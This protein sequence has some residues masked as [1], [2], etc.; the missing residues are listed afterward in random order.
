M[1]CS[2]CL[3]VVSKVCY[4]YCL[5][6]YSW[7]CL[8]TINDLIPEFTKLFLVIHIFLII[9]VIINTFL[10]IFCKKVF[11]SKFL[12][13]NSYDLRFEIW[14]FRWGMTNFVWVWSRGGFY[15]PYLTNT[16]NLDQ[17]APHYR[18]TGFFH[19]NTSLQ[20]IETVKTRFRGIVYQ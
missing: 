20:P 10:G 8:G 1:S 17:P 6:G 7:F 4:F 19:T 12:T 15:Q 3:L 18:E 5:T 9:S 11:D 16:N 14:D 13:Y 2:I